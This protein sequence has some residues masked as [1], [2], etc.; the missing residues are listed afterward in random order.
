VP[1]ELSGEVEIVPG[2][3]GPERIDAV[4]RPAT[5]ATKARVPDPIVRVEIEFDHDQHRYVCDQVTVHPGTTEVLR[6]VPVER[7][8]VEE[9]AKAGLMPTVTTVGVTDSVGLSDGGS[10]TLE[11]WGRSVA[12]EVIEH[13]PTDQALRWVAH[14]YRWGFAVSYGGTKAVEELLGLPRS[15]AGRWVE[16]ARE[17]GYLGPP[18]GPGKA[19]I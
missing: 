6:Q 16:M 19:G 8:M 2:I 9:L 5:I 1:R 17:A 12:E 13:G 14:L 4:V 10:R 18:E 11:P 15:T 3:V 7:L